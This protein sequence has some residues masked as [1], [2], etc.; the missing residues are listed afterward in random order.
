[1]QLNERTPKVSAGG[2]G[3]VGL[4]SSCEKLHNWHFTKIHRITFPIWL[5]EEFL[6]KCF[7]G[8]S[9]GSANANQM[10]PFNFLPIKLVG[11]LTNLEPF[12]VNKLFQ[13]WIKRLVT[14][15]NCFP[16]Q[17]NYVV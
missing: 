6:I 7:R 14:N 1:M 3:S 2:H 16:W 10:T 5:R 8:K 4:I 15:K 13:I 9:W 12:L 11:G 17:N